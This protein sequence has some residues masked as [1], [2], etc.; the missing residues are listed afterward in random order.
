MAL[1]QVA[2]AMAPLPTT[3]VDVMMQ[4]E[5]VEITYWED[6]VSKQWRRPKEELTERTLQRMGK[7]LGTEPSLLDHTGNIVEPS[8]PCHAAWYEAR[9]FSTNG[10][11]VEIYRDPP[12]I[13]SLD[14]SSEVAYEGVPVV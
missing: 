13:T 1:Q 7:K 14:M 9:F 6:A 8:L 2:G 3:R 5:T 4:S 12:V 11:L 10:T